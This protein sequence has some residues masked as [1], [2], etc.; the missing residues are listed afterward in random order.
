[1]SNLSS[2]QNA[3]T[4]NRWVSSA[5]WR[6]EGKQSRSERTQTTILDATERLLVTQGTDATLVADIAKEAGCSIGSVYHHFK[7]KTAIFY[8]LFHR[9]T[10]DFEY[11]IEYALDPALWE[12]ASIQDILGRFIDLS[13]KTQESRPGYKVAA[14]LIAA[15]HPE[16]RNHYLELQIKLYKGLERLLLARKEDIRHPKPK[17]AVGF[18]LDQLG[19]LLRVNLDPAQRS[20]QLVAGSDRVLKEEFL[21]ASESYLN[22]SI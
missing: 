20:A 16:L 11:F 10:Q 21:R 9:T 17:R 19:A 12:G 5:H 6:R 3:T 15:D 22:S 2:Q 8:A 1:M 7:D 13:R 14:Y 18:V 4:E